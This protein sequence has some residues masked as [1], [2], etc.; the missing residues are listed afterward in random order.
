MS[1]SRNN[2]KAISK[3]KS[4]EDVDLLL[5]RIDEQ[6]EQIT[7]LQSKFRGLILEAFHSK[8]D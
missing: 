2:P 1:S 6:N 7:R 5:N 4:S 8:I 3:P